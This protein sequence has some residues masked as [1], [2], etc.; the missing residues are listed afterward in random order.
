MDNN[1]KESIKQDLVRFENQ[2]K[3]RRLAQLGTAAGLGTLGYGAFKGS[4][5][6]A[7][8]GA[9]ITGLGAFT[10]GRAA[11]ERDYALGRIKRH[12]DLR[13][14]QVM[15]LGAVLPSEE[16]ISKTANLAK[17]AVVGESLTLLSHI[18]DYYHSFSPAIPAVAATAAAIGKSALPL[19]A[20]LAAL[21]GIAKWQFQKGLNYAHVFA[22][23]KIGK[24]LTSSE[25][26]MVAKAL[27]A[28]ASI[29]KANVSKMPIIGPLRR[30]F[31]AYHGA[32]GTGSQI[33]EFAGTVLKHVGEVSPRYQ[34]LGLNAINDPKAR[35]ILEDTAK[36][37][38]KIL[39]KGVDAAKQT[40]L[41]KILERFGSKGAPGAK[42]LLS[43]IVENP[44]K[45][46][47]L[48]DKYK[49]IE[50]RITHTGKVMAGGI[51]GALA[52]GALGKMRTSHPLKKDE[53][54]QYIASSQLEQLKKM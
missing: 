48:V 18:P 37:D 40:R 25:Q 29:A 12:Y 42:K 19:M 34:D 49:D 31:S 51:G 2:K 5:H 44:Q 21:P 32:P 20:D 45:L 30:Y 4:P 27:G 10:A 16:D 6:A 1:H 17:T 28:Q 11:R 53:L 41:A 54:P 35:K 52:I 38:W 26:S 36:A 24:P 46:E 15:D 3:I 13:D 9:G 7:T 22:K 47:E 33:G 14:K 23:A 50:N 8:L 39:E 43:D